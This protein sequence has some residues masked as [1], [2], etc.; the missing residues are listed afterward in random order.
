MFFNP[1][2]PLTGLCL[3]LVFGQMV[4]WRLWLRRSNNPVYRKIVIA[5]YIVFNVGWLMTIFLFFQP[6]DSFG[7][8][9]LCFIW[10]PAMAWQLLQAFIVL[11]AA[12]VGW[13]IL[14]LIRKI[15]SP[16]RSD[17][18]QG[19]KQESSLS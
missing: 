6:S 1:I 9:I 5:F 4:S 16:R 10:L 17:S 2:I 13:L 3:A 19:T 14:F 15:I 11:P 18:P 8:D 7:S 12:A